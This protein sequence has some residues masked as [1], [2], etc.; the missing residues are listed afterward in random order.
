[1]VYLLLASKSMMKK[2]PK[3]TPMN[4]CMKRPTSQ[5]EPQAGPLQGLQKAAFLPQ[6][7][8]APCVIAPED[9]PFSQEVTLCW[10]SLVYLS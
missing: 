4:L 5:E 10:C 8:T 9:L 2:G 3:Q 6:E 7:T 1:M